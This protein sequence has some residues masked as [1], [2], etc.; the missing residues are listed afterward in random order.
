MKTKK[1]YQNKDM[2][3]VY[4]FTNY[5][6]SIEDKGTTFNV[7]WWRKDDTTGALVCM[8]VTQD[9][10]IPNSNGDSWLEQK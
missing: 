7:T 10:F 9:F 6:K 4:I 5:L 8:D 1:M 2:K 3:G